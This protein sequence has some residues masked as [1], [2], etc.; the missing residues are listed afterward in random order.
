L[1]SSARRGWNGELAVEKGEK[2]LTD[3][4]KIGENSKEK[5]S[6]SAVR[7]DPRIEAFVRM[8]AR[9]A[10]ERDFAKAVSIHGKTHNDY[11]KKE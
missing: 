4:R 8:L 1:F 11:K 2:A 10:A 5:A 9:K 3:D 7:P 6:A